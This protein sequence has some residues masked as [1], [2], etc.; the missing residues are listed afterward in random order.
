VAD[1]LD[2][3]VLGPLEVRRGGAH[4][5]VGAPKQRA[6][7]TALALTPG[8]AV[9][10]DTLVD[11]LWADRPPP[12]VLATVQAYVS[13]LR[14]VLEPQRARRAPARVL[15][16]QAPG[17][18]LR[19]PPEATDAG[20]FERAVTQWH[21]RLSLPLLGPS[22]VSVDDLQEGA[23]ALDAALALWRGR[24]YAELGDASAPAAERTHLDELRLVALEARAAARLALGDHGTTAA[25]LETLTGQH[26][27]RERLWALR[28]L[29]LVR[30]GRQGEALDALRGVRGVLA[31]EL[32]IDPGAELR[33]LQ[34]RILAQDPALD[35]SPAEARGPTAAGPSPEPPPDVPTTPAA[36]S[37]TTAD[38]VAQDGGWPLLGRDEEMGRLLGRLDR[39]GEGEA[40]FAVVTG[41]PGIGKS[42]LCTELVSRAAARGATVLVG[43]CSQD[44]GAPP[45]WPWQ[46]ALGALGASLPRSDR[47]GG[48]FAVWATITRTVLEAAADHPV[49]LLLDDLHWADTATLRVL[50]LLVEQA[51]GQRLLVLATWR[52]RPAPT[53]ALADA[54]EALARAHAERLELTGLDD[55][56]VAGILDAVSHRRPTASEATSLRRRTDGNPFFL[57]EYARLAATRP[58]LG[59]LLD[60]E[61]RPR[62]VQE[63]LGRRIDRLPEETRRVLR[64]A[65]VIGRRFELPVLA[66]SSGTEVDDVLDLLEPAQVAGLVR[67]DSVDTFVFEHA[68]VRDTA[69]DGVSATRRARM[70][71]AVAAVLEGGD[72]H[73]TEVARHWLAAGPAH[74]GRAWRAARA[75]GR[76]ALGAHAHPEAAE[77]FDAALDRLSD[78]PEAD[79]RQR[80]DLLVQRAVAERWG[81]RW[82]ALTATVEEAVAV[83]GDLGDPVLAAEAATLT[84]RGALWQSARHSGVH[85][86]IV[87]ALRRSLEVLPDEDS[88]V[89]CRCLIGLASETY[90]VSPVEERRALV[91]TAVAMARRLG[92]P[93]LLI[94][95][96][97][98]AYNARWVPGAEQEGLAYAEQALELAREVGDEHAEVVAL[99]QMAISLAELGRPR[100]M[101]DTYRL[102]VAGAERLRL[103]YALVVLKSL[104]VPWHAMAG[105]F[106]ECERLLSEVKDHVQQ[107]DLSQADEAITG[108]V[109]AITLWNPDAPLSTETVAVSDASPLPTGTTIAFLLWAHGEEGAARAWLAAHPADLTQ[110]DWFSK[111]NWGFAGA[112]AAFTGDRDLAARVYAL[113]APYA[114]HACTAGSGLASGPM[115][116]FLALSAYAAGERELASGHADAA[117]RLAEAWEIP[118]FTAWFREQRDRYDF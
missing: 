85:E 43:R 76:I 15:V 33:E 114:G 22:P 57:V 95:T 27:L 68:L 14:K 103:L 24:P 97:S 98:G 47:E 69:Y 88:P 61:E 6:L 53:G 31:E 21:R 29:A 52:D 112:M 5:D 96:L 105:R 91:E 11:L 66:A 58:D 116:G 49:V 12:G 20:R 50:R 74:A 77:L 108:I 87:A 34:A 39:A 81:A 46:V 3:L 41:E 36:T 99:T 84:L 64:T 26:P 73:E 8:R 44:D 89:R 10:V 40:G 82:G 59:G 118:L 70:H 67:E 80:Y 9:A 23:A 4:V 1:D 38:T 100:A 113:I 71:A 111:L 42:R 93:V 110:H 19:V 17:Y 32:G 54:A 86:H 115:D 30:S 102:A 117:E 92:D 83:A 90:Y 13:S 94:D 55:S 62:A 51:A 48:E 25:E 107:A 37:E 106:E 56:S 45:L 63:V 65:A 18:A 16:T 72:G 79:P 7:L 2:L 78:D 35:W 101:W 75:A 109:G 104:A 60:G 28:A